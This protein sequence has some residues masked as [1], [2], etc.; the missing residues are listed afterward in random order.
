[1]EVV[2]TVS[3]PTG[4]LAQA[5]YGRTDFFVSHMRAVFHLLPSEEKDKFLEDPVEFTSG[6]LLFRGLTPEKMAHFLSTGIMEPQCGQQNSLAVFET[7]SP[8]FALT[9]ATGH[10]PALAVID[11]SKIVPLTPLTAPGTEEYKRLWQ[12][13]CGDQADSNP[14]ELQNCIDTICLSSGGHQWHNIELR[15]E[16][17]LAEVKCFSVEHEGALLLLDPSDPNDFQFLSNLYLG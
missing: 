4:K 13:V 16:Q 3:I 2:D 17:P 8:Y 11:P 7:D 10:L 12:E 15:K 9:F 1:M 5:S 14:F 6:Q